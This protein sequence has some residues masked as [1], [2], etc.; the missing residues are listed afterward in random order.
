MASKTVLICQGKTCRKGEAAKV[1]AAFQAIAPED[2]EIIASGCM[3]QCGNGPMVVVLP[4]QVWYHRVSPE[5]VP[6]VVERHLRQGKPVQT[7]LY[8]RHP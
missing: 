8:L 5:E 6:T 2:V 4:D 1:L 3:G 7:M